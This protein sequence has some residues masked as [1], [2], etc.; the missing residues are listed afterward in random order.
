MAN[1]LICCA[2]LWGDNVAVIVDAVVGDFPQVYG[3]GNYFQ[4]STADLICATGSF[5]INAPNGLFFLKTFPF[6]I[7]PV[8]GTTSNIHA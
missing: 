2:E 4:C 8:S 5:V 1:S 7:R 6:L 3:R